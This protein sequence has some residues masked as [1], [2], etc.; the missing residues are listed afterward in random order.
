MAS[1]ATSFVRAPGRLGDA[2]RT[3]PVRG[4]LRA[5]LRE[6]VIEGIEGLKSLVI[7]F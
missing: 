4:I 3:L 7:Q 2:L 5:C 6:R 1:K